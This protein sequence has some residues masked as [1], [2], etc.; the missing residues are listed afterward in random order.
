MYDVDIR[1]H[2]AA[3]FL[4]NLLNKS[5][6]LAVVTSLLTDYFLQQLNERTANQGANIRHITP[7]KFAECL[8]SDSP[9]HDGG[10]ALVNNANHSDVD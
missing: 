5:K 1:V 7:E 3:S 2:I 8:H 4:A 10:V 9:E 6:I